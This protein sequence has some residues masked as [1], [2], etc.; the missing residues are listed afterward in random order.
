LLSA[1]PGVE[2][3]VNTTTAGVQR[4]HVQGGRSIDAAADDSYV[5]VWSS[6][7]G[8][9]SGWG[10]FARQFDAAGTPTSGEI[11]V[12]TFTAGDQNN[13]AVAVRDDGSFV[14]VW[15]S[16]LQDGSG[17]GVYAREFDATGTPVTAEIPVTVT[18]TG[19]QQMP[20]IAL[21]AGGGY[22]IAWSGRGP[23][24][25]NGTFARV[26]ADGGAPVTGEIAV[27][28]TT[29]FAQVHATIAGDD[30]GGFAVA[31]HGNG[32][33]DRKNVMFR[34]FDGAGAA[35]SGEV[36]VNETLA[37]IQKTPSIAWSDGGH[38]IVAWSGKG[39]GDD[40][41]IF[42][43][44][45]DGAGAPLGSEILVN[46]FLL[47][48]Q[49]EPSVSTTPGGGFFV[50]WAHDAGGGDFDIVAREFDST[51]TPIS[52]DAIIN[53]TIPGVQRSPTAVTV[54]GGA[55]IAWSGPGVGDKFGVFDPIVALG[56]ES[57]VNT[58]TDGVQRTH[59]EGGRSIDAAADDSYVVV[60]SSTV[61][62]GSGWGVFARLF[63]ATGTP[64]SGEIA[65]NTFTADDQNN[66]AVAVRD[67][68]SFVVVWQSK[69][70]DGSGQ[71][72]YTREFDATGTPVT[73]E[74]PVTVTTAGN[75]QLPVI[76]VLSG[77][78]YAIAWSGAGPGDPNGTFA[79]VFAD[80][81]APVTGEIAV[82]E[83]KEF[84]QV[85]A[86]IAADDS[87]GFAVAWHGNGGS[88]RKNVM[89]RHFD[90]TGAALSSEV[91]V[92]ETL[93][94]IQKTPSIAWSDAGHFLVAW[95]GKGAGDD[96]GI[97]VRR[98]DGTGTPLGSEILVNE[99]LPDVQTN[100]SIAALPG[101]GFFVTWAHHTGGGD[102]DIV[103]REFDAADAPVSD[104]EIINT[105]IPGRQWNPTVVAVSDGVR[106]VWSGPGEGDTFG[107]FETSVSLSDEDCDRHHVGHDE[108]HPGQGH[109]HGH[110]D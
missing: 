26:F 78:G 35:L 40:D 102:F 6:T 76:T 63:D 4:T 62:D 98:I 96:S 41:G 80:G 89:F 5:V 58:T 53:S 7:V 48:K 23:G 108:G 29:K 93:A 75:Q 60:W 82:N 54:T 37:G 30:S 57:L 50:A 95:S 106:I 81:G 59:V 103:G 3:L 36:V 28:E 14:V 105:T 52:G 66:A 79:R 18:T 19:N 67:D 43:R 46:E 42:A 73:A 110:C 70:Q 107:V 17:Q 109:G 51:D 22:A 100:P 49:T 20:A 68:G 65:V 77:G 31:W 92:N 71:G 101:G 72:V 13:S 12:N 86:T 10:V 21:R 34:H 55:R 85:Y 15:Q 47:L 84:N 91:V 88:D 38:F 1:S 104:D 99:T 87:G 8:D 39:T 61:G 45:I 27:N 16:K 33:S 11:A 25:H 56:A 97:F 64:T 94:G 32:G 24:D 44:R 83:T 90:G 2:V 74:I 69:L 9:G